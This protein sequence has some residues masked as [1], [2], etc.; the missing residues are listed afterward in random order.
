MKKKI[1]KSLLFIGSGR[2]AKIWLLELIQK[3][4]LN[5]IYVLTSNTL[6]EY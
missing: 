1:N 4:D 6:N 5:K 2:C 3:I